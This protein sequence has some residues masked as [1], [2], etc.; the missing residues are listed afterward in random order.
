MV[1]VISLV[2]IGG[3][4]LWGMKKGFILEI[5]EIAGLILAFVLSIQLPIG[6]NIG[7]WKY[8]V[9]FLIYFLIISIGFTI[10]SKSINKT[11]LALIDRIL[12][13]AIGAIKGLIVVIIIFLIISIV[14]G[15]Q[16][17]ANLN[18]SI[19]YKNTLKIRPVLKGFLQRKVEELKPEE[20]IKILEKHKGKYLLI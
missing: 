5:S 4:L 1:D 8:L 13:A 6:L 18:N 19:I 3:F 10:L 9:S 14:P 20:K 16:S 7:G 2:V 15:S 12:G 17:D 11:P